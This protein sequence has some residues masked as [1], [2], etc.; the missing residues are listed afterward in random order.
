MRIANR[1]DDTRLNR[2][3][4]FS[5]RNRA[6]SNRNSRYDWQCGQTDAAGNQ[7]KRHFILSL[8]LTVS[9]SRVLGFSCRRNFGERCGT[10]RG[11]TSWELEG[12]SP[13]LFYARVAVC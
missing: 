9:S 8:D 1:C 5:R 2:R 12:T 4:C 6:T 13:R 10:R 3:I 11:G 7:L